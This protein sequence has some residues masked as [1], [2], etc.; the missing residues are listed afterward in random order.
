MSTL[1]RIYTEFL[2]EQFLDDEAKEGITLS[3]ADRH[4]IK[5]LPLDVQHDARQTVL[6][7]A[8]RILKK[9]FETTHAPPE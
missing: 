7:N 2:D 4:L 9:G 1:S 5:D 8:E 6:K 3:I